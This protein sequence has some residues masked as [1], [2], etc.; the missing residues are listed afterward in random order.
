MNVRIQPARIVASTL[1]LAVLAL[2]AVAAEMTIYKQPYYRGA[3]LT[4]RGHTPSLVG[5]GFQDQASSIVVS[6]GRWE[7]CT[8]PDF[9]GDCVTLG[10]GEYPTLDAR[11]NHRVESAREVGT[12]AA[13]TGGYGRYGRGSIELY[14]QPGFG[15][16]SMQLERD[17]QTLEGTGFNNRASSV[18]VN[19]GH[20]Q[21]CSDS[22]YG[23][24]CRTFAPGRYP[25]LGYGMTKEV[26]SARLVRA[27]RE[28]P[29]V[30]G[31]GV[32]APESA[33]EGSGRV[34]LFGNRNFRGE[35]IAISGVNGALD[36]S[37][38]ND[39]AAS[40]IVE[41]GRWILCT[42]PYFRGE[43]RVIG[44]GRYAALTPLGLDRAISS[45]R[46]AGPADAAPV[47]R[48]NAGADIE[49]YLGPNLQGRALGS[50]KDVVNLGPTDFNDRIGSAV[51][52]NGRWELCSDGEYGGRC[53]V[54]GP[55]QY[56]H[57][58]G[59]TNQVSSFRRVR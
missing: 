10:P 56:P 46:P 55:G 36:R 6:S 49:L 59:L 16:K 19:E 22:D 48:P 29:A 37:G 14:G 47:S 40:M 8:Q 26:S 13:Q 9:K 43:C 17:A 41:G 2:P 24:T 5:I 3:Q 54:V 27:Q 15:G 52:H 51:V 4:L 34:I 32:N 1:A 12:Y 23:G 7:L 31:P 20:W 39:A 28:A 57:L 33:A 35:S 21:L 38:F 25:D 30:L 18:I 11:L 53:I 44:P 42:E 45:I 58:G 50:K